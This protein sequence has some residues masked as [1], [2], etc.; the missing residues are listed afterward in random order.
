M[1]P[2]RSQSFVPAFARG[3]SI[4]RIAENCGVSYGGVVAA[5]ARHN[6]TGPKRRHHTR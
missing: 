1:T 4:A 3:K 2:Q 6:G 5:Y